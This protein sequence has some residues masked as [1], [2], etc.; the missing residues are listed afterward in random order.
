MY[1]L[2]VG[3]YDLETLARIPVVDGQGNKI[4][5]RAPL[6]QIEVK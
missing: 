3:W 2:E 5:D 4:D 1:Q 6:V